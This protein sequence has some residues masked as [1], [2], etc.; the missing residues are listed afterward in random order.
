M[1]SKWE[2]VSYA[3]VYIFGYEGD[4]W[5]GTFDALIACTAAVVQHSSDL[6]IGL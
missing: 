1:R 2:K 3:Q 4:R 5:N 6:I